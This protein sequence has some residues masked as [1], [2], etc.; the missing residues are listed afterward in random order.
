[1][2]VARLGDSEEAVYGKIDVYSVT[3]TPTGTHSTG[4]SPVLLE[5]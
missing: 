4:W 5:L 1:M 2:L 3:L